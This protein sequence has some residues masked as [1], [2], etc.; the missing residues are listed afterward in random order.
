MDNT[1]QS[2]APNDAAVVKFACCKRIYGGGRGYRGSPC[3]K[4]ATVKR[5]G[6]WY[7]TVHD[8]VR[9]ASLREERYAKFTAQCEVNTKIWRLE[10]AAPD[11]LAALI[12]ARKITLE[13]AEITGMHRPALICQIDAAIAKATGAP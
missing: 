6:N 11:M 3:S 12:E 5:E 13:T 7:C 9:A 8:P 2:A 1:T 10:K 4:R